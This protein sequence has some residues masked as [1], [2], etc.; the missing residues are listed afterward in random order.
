MC[1]LK[2]L[3]K[4][5]SNGRAYMTGMGFTNLMMYITTHTVTL[6]GVI[7]SLETVSIA[8][9]LQ[10]ENV[11]YAVALKIVNDCLRA[12]CFFLQ[13]FLK[14]NEQHLFSRNNPSAKLCTHDG[15]ILSPVKMSSHCDF[16]ILKEPD[17]W[18]ILVNEPLLGKCED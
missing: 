3:V 18:L 10:L 14:A 6:S 11:Q 16:E 9:N 4:F 5:A 13:C 2:S 12:F 1:I 7:S 15:L 8:V 17:V